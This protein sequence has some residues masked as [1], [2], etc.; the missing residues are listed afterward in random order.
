MKRIRDNNINTVAYW[1]KIHPEH[2]EK[3][4]RFIAANEEI[5]TQFGTESGN[6]IHVLDIGCADGLAAA[7]VDFDYTGTDFSPVAIDMAK[8]MHPY[9]RFHVAD[10]DKQPFPDGYFGGEMSGEVIEH[11]E[12]PALLVIDMKRLCRKDGL[13]ILSTPL[14]SC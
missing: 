14:E 3:P 7:H 11:V 13:I 9:A 2:R 1:D 12:Q 10:Y 5:I 8:R 6:A 4:D